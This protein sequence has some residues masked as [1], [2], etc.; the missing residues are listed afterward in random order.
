MMGSL[1]LKLLFDLLI[2][3]ERQEQMVLHRPQ[4]IKRTNLEMQQ[5]WRRM[6]AALSLSLR[7]WTCFYK[8][9]ADDMAS[10]LLAGT[11]SLRL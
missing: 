2:G 3:L 4:L 1:H 11:R 7:S 5:T 8:F 6:G 9:V 10:M